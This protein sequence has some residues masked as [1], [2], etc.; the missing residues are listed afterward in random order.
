MSTDLKNPIPLFD[1]VDFLFDN[2]GDVDFALVSTL[3]ADQM[4]ST[5]DIIGK[6]SATSSTHYS[7]YTM[8]RSMSVIFSLEG[9]LG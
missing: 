7:I 5:V 3:S 9:V 6:V 2:R 4:G 1:D 8:R